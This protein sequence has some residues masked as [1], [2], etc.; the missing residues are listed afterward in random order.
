MESYIYYV[1]IITIAYLLRGALRNSFVILVSFLPQEQFDRIKELMPIVHENSK[2]S[3]LEGLLSGLTK[4]R[5]KETK[6]Q[7][8]DLPGFITKEVMGVSKAESVLSESPE[9]KEPIPA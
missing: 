2:P 1:L 3:P 9:D 6:D 7:K 5:S 4:P 8:Q